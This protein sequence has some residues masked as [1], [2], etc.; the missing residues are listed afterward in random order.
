MVN[1]C[2]GRSLCQKLKVQLWLNLEYC[3]CW[4]SHWMFSTGS[5]YAGCP[6]FRR[7]LQS[8]PEPGF[9]PGQ[10][11]GMFPSLA[12]Q[13]AA[14]WKWQTNLKASHRPF[15]LLQV[16]TATRSR[17]WACVYFEI[18]RDCLTYNGRVSMTRAQ[19]SILVSPVEYQRRWDKVAEKLV[20]FV[21]GKC[22]FCGEGSLKRS[23][24]LFFLGW[25]DHAGAAADPRTDCHV[26]AGAA[27]EH[28]HPQ[29]A[30]SEDCRRSTVRIQLI[31]ALEKAKTFSTSV[32]TSNTEII[33]ETYS[34]CHR[35]K[36]LIHLIPFCR[37][38]ISS[39]LSPAT[40]DLKI[41]PEL[42]MFPHFCLIIS[43]LYVV[44]LYENTRLQT[45]RQTES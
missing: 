21:A 14:L 32:I 37:N 8:W 15:M 2:A 24:C 5:W 39:T 27:A 3:Y 38:W 16:I 17:N 41:S 7:R 36:V 34:F 19:R 23:W 33:L 11:K 29:R 18:S 30:D 28:P 6:S 35:I 20:C 22:N 4:E 40:T 10:G 1:T 44:F 13:F 31:K 9:Q 42:E 43:L 25:T 45:D 12:Q 26:A